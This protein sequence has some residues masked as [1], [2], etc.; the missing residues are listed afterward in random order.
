MTEPSDAFDQR[1]ER[2][3]G[4]VQLSSEFELRLMARVHA[5]RDYLTGVVAA[6]QKHRRLLG[7]LTLDAVAAGALLLFGEALM[8]HVV[9]STHLPSS[10]ALLGLLGLVPVA[11]VLA[12]LW[13][14]LDYGRSPE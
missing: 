11:A 14:G 10:G 3:F 7:F 12:I 2:L 5:E 4:S 8:E 1:L 13:R 9:L 6:T